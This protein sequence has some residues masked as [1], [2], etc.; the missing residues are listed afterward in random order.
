MKIIHQNRKARHNYEIST[1]FE[2]GI[3]LL[4]SEVKALREGRCNLG[5]GW[6]DLDTGEAILKDVHIG[7]YKHANI[8]NHEETRERRL[9][10]QKPELKKLYQAVTQ[11][12]MAVVPLKIYFAKNGL[13][14]VEIAIGK[15]KKLH[16]KREAGKKRDAERQMQRALKNR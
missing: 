3:S 7:H 8:Q 10:L 15:G 4:G 6:V 1:K 14:K 13:I 9:L 11:K 2:A 16:D 5:E 12:G